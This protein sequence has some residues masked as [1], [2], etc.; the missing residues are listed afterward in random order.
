[1]ISLGYFAWSGQ[2]KNLLITLSRIDVTSAYLTGRFESSIS[3]GNI[4]HEKESVKNS[5]STCEEE[6]ERTV[7]DFDDP[8]NSKF[9]VNDNSNTKFKKSQKNKKCFF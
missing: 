4:F 5:S 1:M 6:K 3:G 9:D 2:M 7:F 8:F